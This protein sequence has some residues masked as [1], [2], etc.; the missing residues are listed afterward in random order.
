VPSSASSKTG[1]SEKRVRYP[2]SRVLTYAAQKLTTRAPPCTGF[3][4]RRLHLVKDGRQR[5][6]RQVAVQEPCIGFL[7]QGFDL[8][9]RL[10][11]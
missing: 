3:P 11:V 9:S 10:L 2:S 8:V 7:S 4:N 5:G 1:A 6:A